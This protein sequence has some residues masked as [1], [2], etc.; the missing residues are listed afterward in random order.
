MSMGWGGGGW[1]DSPWGG[2]S[3]GVLSLLSALAIAENAVLLTFTM[4]IYFSE[5]RDP[6]DASQPKL[7][8]IATD[9][10]SVGLDGTIAR[11][12][13]SA[14][15]A[16]AD[17]PGMLSGAQVIITTDRPFTPF[18][19]I[20]SVSCSSFIQN[21]DQTQSIV[22]SGT[23]A[24][25]QGTF[26]QIVTPTLNLPDATTS[27]IASPDGLISAIAANAN[28]NS[29]QFVLGVPVIDASGDY[30]TDSGL[31]NTRKRIIR[32]ILF[33]PGA[34]V[35]LGNGYGVGAT[36]YG[37]KLNSTSTRAKL[38]ASTE[39]QIS[40]EPD[41]AAVSCIVQADKNNTGEFYLISLVKT[42]NGQSMRVTV[43]VTQTSI[44]S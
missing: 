15:V 13:S 8:T 2:Y 4:P 31:I 33:N 40:Q 22:S 16:L 41:V 25:F 18:P 26:K 43:P 9:T 20:Y 23:V 44:T 37:K 12:V 35:H 30:A 17:N 38:A 6:S 5:L 34:T 10:R 1:G 29:N 14:A 21:A 19:S 3:G 32:R 27:D 39:S 7:F 28:Y 36:S 42:R 24:Q 11:P